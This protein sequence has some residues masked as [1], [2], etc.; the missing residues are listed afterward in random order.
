M[1][2]HQGALW[3]ALAC[4]A[5]VFRRLP[6]WPL[7]QLAARALTERWWP[8]VPPDVQA[9]LSGGTV[10]VVVTDLGLCVRLVAGARGISAASVSSTHTVRIQAQARHLMA[11]MQGDEDPDTLFFDRRLVMEGMGQ[12]TAA[13]ASRIAA[14]A[15]GASGVSVSIL[16]PPFFSSASRVVDP[17]LD[18]PSSSPPRRRSP[19]PTK[20][21]A[22]HLFRYRKQTMPPRWHS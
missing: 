7:A 18:G 4:G 12:A 3:Q 14:P 10:E 17:L 6:T 5:P 22:R 19:P 21:W 13:P 16:P 20:Q 8:L 15:G 1:M 9:Q 2:R 11:L